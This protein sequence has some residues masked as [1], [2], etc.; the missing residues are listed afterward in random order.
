MFSR[1][2]LVVLVLGFLFVEITAQTGLGMKAGL[3]ISNDKLCD[4][5]Y[6]YLPERTTEE[7]YSYGFGLFYRM[8]VSRLFS[9]APSI[10]FKRKG[11]ASM[12]GLY[13]DDYT[14]I[15]ERLGLNLQSEW[16]LLNRIHLI[17]GPELV[18]SIGQVNKEGG[19]SVRGGLIEVKK[20]FIVNGGLKVDLS[21]QI[22]LGMRYQHSFSSY[23]DIQFFDTTGSPIV[24]LDLFQQAFIAEVLYTLPR[25][26]E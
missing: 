15:S 26:K 17:I 10:E 20:D 5:D 2:I 25:F 21:T 14:F 12:N 9:I 6:V 13:G 22:S 24:R 19:K 7:L 11:F 3:V 8:E 18:Y 1:N 16:R 4:D 23:S